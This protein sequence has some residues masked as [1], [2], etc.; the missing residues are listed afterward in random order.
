[1]LKL[2][3]IHRPSNS[4]RRS[5]IHKNQ[6]WGLIRSCFGQ[7]GIID[8]LPSLAAFGQDEVNGVNI[9]YMEA[10]EKLC[11]TTNNLALEE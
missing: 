3:L 8:R 9:S 10:L 11:G 1:M 5:G 7:Y 6:N 4:G 2:N